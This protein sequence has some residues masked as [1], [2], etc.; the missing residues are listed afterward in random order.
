MPAGLLVTGSALNWVRFFPLSNR[1]RFVI[2]HFLVH[3]YAIGTSDGWRRTRL[4][5]AVFN[6]FI[7]PLE[8][9]RI[10]FLCRRWAR[11]KADTQH[12]PTDEVF[13]NV[14]PYD[15]VP[16]RLPTNDIG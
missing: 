8:I 3:A 9:V 5:P 16:T 12:H 15:P 11:S 6:T 13:H 10:H 2:V 4:A 7:D 14:A 1:A